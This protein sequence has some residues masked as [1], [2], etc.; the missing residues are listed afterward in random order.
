MT[1]SK[2]DTILSD[3]EQF[4]QHHQPQ[5]QSFHPYFQTAVWEMVQNGGKR[6]RPALILSVVDSYAPSLTHNAYLPALAMEILHTFSL[7]HDDLPSI[8]NAPLRR[9]HPTLHTKY[10]EITAILS[11]DFLNS[12]AFYLI[13]ISPLDAQSKVEL[14]KTLSLNA[15]QMIVGEALDCYFENKTLELDKL[16]TIHTLKTAKLIASSLKMG[17]IIANLDLQ[18]QEC[19]WDFGILLGVFF[20]IRDDVI[21]ATQT[22]EEAGKTTQNDQNK[23]SYVNLL[24]LK[25]A[26]NTLKRYQAT[27]QEQIQTLQNPRLQ[28]HLNALLSHY[29]C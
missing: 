15:T 28:Q 25:E 18:T 12:Y 16:Q 23:N 9:S 27:L 8:D 11:G 7:I 3:F 14:T 20:Q 29:F 24:G 5:A 19:L 21:D 26:Q 4:L 10:E 1:T 13:S 2:I 22:Q 6:F 17:A